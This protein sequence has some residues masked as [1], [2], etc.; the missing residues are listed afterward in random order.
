M[1]FWVVL[2]RK[3]TLPVFLC[4]AY[5]FP[6]I[7]NAIYGLFWRFCLLSVASKQGDATCEAPSEGTVL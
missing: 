4:L 6:Y 7:T 2:F 5:N 3:I 1:I